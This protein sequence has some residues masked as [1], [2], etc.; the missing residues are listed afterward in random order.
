M[1]ATCALEKLVGTHAILLSKNEVWIFGTHPTTASQIWTPLPP[2]PLSPV[3]SG[4]QQAW[5]YP[6]TLSPSPSTALSDSFGLRP[7]SQCEIME[8]ATAGVHLHPRWRCAA[9][10]PWRFT[11]C[12]VTTSSVLLWKNTSAEAD[13]E[14]ATAGNWAHT[15]IQTRTHIQISA[16]GPTHAHTYTH[17]YAH[18][19]TGTQT[20]GHTWVRTGR[21]DKGAGRART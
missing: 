5:I 17:G 19:Y 7:R 16:H 15:H 4:Q 9:V 6:I 18:I 11:S 8:K 13:A 14:V 12:R 10:W 2:C 3:S 1:R 20:H 21:G